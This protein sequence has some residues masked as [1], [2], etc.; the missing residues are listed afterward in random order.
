MCKYCEQK[1]WRKTKEYEDIYDHAILLGD[2]S[3]WVGLYMGINEWGQYVL[4]AS[5]DDESRVH[6]N[7]CP[8]CGKKL[9]EDK[10]NIDSIKD[11]EE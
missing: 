2:D 11:D 8:I 7:Y 1:P 9:T 4:V 10:A 5:G 3:L 6:I